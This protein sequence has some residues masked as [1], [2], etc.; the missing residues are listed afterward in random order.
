MADSDQSLYTIRYNQTTQGMEGFGGGTPMWTPLALV[1][2]GGINQLHGDASAGPGVG[3]QALTLA[4]VNSNV[5][6]FTNAS[7]TVNAKG[8]ITAAANGSSFSGVSSVHA[9]SSANLTGDVQLVS[10]TNVTL[11]QVGQAI[12]INSSGGGNGITQLTGD[13][14][15]GPG[16]GSQVIT[17]NSVTGDVS[18][19]PVAA[20]KVGEL[21]E[22][23]VSPVSTVTLTTGVNADV[24]SIDLTA[25]LWDINA[26]ICF[27]GTSTDATTLYGG[28]S[29]TTGNSFTG[30]ME[31]LNAFQTSAVFNASGDGGVSVPSFRQSV[32]SPITLY[33]KAYCVF[34]TGTAAAFGRISARRVA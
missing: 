26:I 5:G 14:T 33:L 4:A 28:V 10:G 8:L 15:A 25:G 19:N 12:T 17:V 6:S 30:Q 3:N 11:S 34:S 29:P 16:S 22:V 18:G 21:V 13:A 27:T 23:Y 31:G 9:D 1:A 24:T 2:D 20:G 7:I 32:P